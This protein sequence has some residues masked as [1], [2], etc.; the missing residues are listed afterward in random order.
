MTQRHAGW[1]SKD[2][3]SKSN[4]QGSAIE[5]AGQSSQ[6]KWKSSKPRAKWKDISRNVRN[7]VCPWKK[8]STWIKSCKESSKRETEIYAISEGMAEDVKVDDGDKSRL[9]GAL[10]QLRKDSE[11]K[12]RQE[13]S[14]KKCSKTWTRRR[15]ER[16]N[17]SRVCAGSSTNTC[18][19]VN[20]KLED[21]TTLAHKS[22]RW[23]KA[24][25]RSLTMWKVASQ[26]FCRK[27]ICWSGTKQWKRSGFGPKRKRWKSQSLVKWFWI[28]PANGKCALIA[29]WISLG[30][31]IKLQELSTLISDI[32]KA[33]EDK[34]T[35]DL[36]G[37]QV[38]DDMTDE[39][40]EFLYGEG[41][42][43]A[44]PG[45]RIRRTEKVDDRVA[46]ALWN[47]WGSKQMKASERPE[48]PSAYLF[49]DQ[50]GSVWYWDGDPLIC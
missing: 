35:M 48:M 50:N 45:W 1:S 27:R 10:K 7:W 8:K 16:V 4:W 5:D 26:K 49:P 42:C 12:E 25:A 21:R 31:M 14:W 46:N 29:E 32:L 38:W 9:S 34:E 43:P 11:R 36:I 37:D 47:G 28:K 13:N 17:R 15:S 33:W 23:C 39:W 2:W 24:I 30:E 3:S 22:G 44:L 20:E 41:N 18:T 40:A 6:D 19:H